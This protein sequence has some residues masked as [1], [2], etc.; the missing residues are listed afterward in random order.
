MKAYGME[1]KPHYYL[2]SALD[3]GEWWASRPDRFTLK[4]TA[5]ETIELD[6]E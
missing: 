4:E 2:T 6:A 1:L 5:P 3:E